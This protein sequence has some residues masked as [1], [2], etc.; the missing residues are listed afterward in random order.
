LDGSN[1]NSAIRFCNRLDTLLNNAV[2]GYEGSR[3]PAAAPHPCYARKQIEAA[4]QS[5]RKT[6]TLAPRR[7]F[8]AKLA[9]LGGFAALSGSIRAKAQTASNITA[10]T[11]S[12]TTGCR[13]C[14]P[15]RK[16]QEV[17]RPSS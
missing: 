3:L 8:F 10:Q 1:L 6:M 7:E 4:R 17:F 11:L 12:A 16:A 5:R 9:L 2:L 14:S 13:R 15:I